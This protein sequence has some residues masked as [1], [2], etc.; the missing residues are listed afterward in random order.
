[1]GNS[2]WARELVEV[3]KTLFLNFSDGEILLLQMYVF[4]HVHHTHVWQLYQVQMSYG[5][6]KQ[7]F[8]IFRNMRKFI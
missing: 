4:S 6:G 5:S 1:M 3:T 7:R 2:S 8:D